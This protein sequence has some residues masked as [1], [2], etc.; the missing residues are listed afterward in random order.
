MKIIVELECV[1]AENH[2]AEEIKAD[3]RCGENQIGWYYDYKIKSI[4]VTE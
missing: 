4:D 2:A 1:D 3:L